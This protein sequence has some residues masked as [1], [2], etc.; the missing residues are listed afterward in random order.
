MLDYQAGAGFVTHPNW[1]R[2]NLSRIPVAGLQFRAGDWSGDGRTDLLVKNVH[3]QVL[4][5][6]AA[7]GASGNNTFHW[8]FDS[9]SNVVKSTELYSLARIDDDAKDHLVRHDPGTG[10]IAFHKVQFNN[11]QPPALAMNMGNV[12][13]TAGSYLVMAWSHPMRN[14]PG[15]ENRDD[16][17]LFTD[18]NTRVRGHEARWDA[19][20]ARH[21]F[22][23]EYT[24]NAPNNHTGWPAPWSAK[25]L[26]LKCKLQG[27]TS[28]PR[29]AII[30]GLIERIRDYF[31]E[32]TYGRVNI[33]QNQQAPE[34]WQQPP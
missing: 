26:F 24:I 25:T 6:A 4:A 8:A 1:T 17:F 32:V 3:G 27:D 12:P 5:Y 11:G 23:L 22:W 20:D 34:E 7:T 10:A 2:G 30:P 21:T 13:V 29:A 9:S 14:E 28:E 16:P 19:N 31:F 33:W 18:A 15:V